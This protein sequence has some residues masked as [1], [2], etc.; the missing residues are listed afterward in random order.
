MNKPFSA[1]FLLTSVSLI[2]AATALISPAAADTAVIAQSD[3]AA[4][5]PDFTS[6]D[7][8][9][10][11]VKLADFKGKTVV[12][13]FWATWCGPCMQSLPH[14]SELAAKYK[15]Q[16]M[17]VL[18]VCTSDT[19]AKFEEWLKTNQAK[20]PGIVFTHD[21]LEKKPER[22][23]AKLYDVPGIPA[24]F[25]IGPKGE[26]VGRVIGF[27]GA[28]DARTEALLAQA[29]LKVDAALVAKGNAQ[30]KAAAEE[31]AAQIAEEE[32]NPPP[33]FR[34]EL[35]QLKS[36]DGMPDFSLTGPD[37]KEFAFSMFRGKTVVIGI[38]FE[39]VVPA[40]LLQAIGTKHGA[41]GVVPLGMMILS[42]RESYDAWL[43]KNKTKANMLSGW[44]SAAKYSGDYE[45]LDMKAFEAWDAKTALRKIMGGGAMNGTPGFPFFVVV[46]PAGKFIGM[47]FQGKTFD[48][49]LG[50]LLLRAGVK[51][52]PA[53]MPKKVAAAEEFVVKPPPPV[54]A[55]DEVPQ[56]AVGA[57]APDFA[58]TDASGKPVKLAE[59]K[60]KVIVLDFWATWCG[61]CVASMPHTQEVAAKYKDQGVVVIGS[62][63]SDKRKAFEGWVKKNQATYPDFIYAHDAAEKSPERASH[64][65]YGVNGI[66]AQFVI[67]RDGKVAAFVS[68]YM[69]GEVLLEGAL[70]KAGIKVD[71]AIV[72]KAV[73]DQ[74]KRDAH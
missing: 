31:E 46:D 32:A 1:R 50:N 72:A 48:E 14:T 27:D 2:L 55:E 45:K 53:D 56:L 21:P 24:Q 51:L 61:P 28:Q 20:Y 58:M 37:G 35:G 26:L 64:K 7:L 30:I 69:A 47:C 9:G 49:G 41:N 74:K 36:G 12:L 38:G 44:D 65:L 40:D 22:A 33:T 39:D 60:G 18:A 8:A 6:V 57:V 19:R 66:P 43:A 4:A 23:S 11:T 34:P 25:V 42:P 59:F 70:A 62:C 29:G 54:V 13:D 73:E 67:G 52:A 5:A 68:G 3:S 63:T 10:K 17:I 16:G 15:D 71:P